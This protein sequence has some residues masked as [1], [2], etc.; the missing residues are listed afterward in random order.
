MT[1]L[2]PQTLLHILDL[3]EAGA[4]TVETTAAIGAAPKSKIIFTW[5]RASEAAAEFDPPPDPSS[6]W[7]LTWGDKLDFFHLHFLAAKEGGRITRS[8]RV[9][10]IRREVVE[11]LA[12]KRA[13]EPSPSPLRAELEERLAAKRAGQVAN[14]EPSITEQQLPPEKI[15]ERFRV[16]AV[17]ARPL[18]TVN[19]NGPPEAGRFLMVADK[20]KTKEQRRAGTVEITDFGV[21]RW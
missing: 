12:A 3:K 5:L 19:A 14:V 9:P 17:K 4:T 16:S 6:P 13:V 1:I 20:P 18:D 2:S 8:I 10:P 15:I 11:R 21:R 7:C